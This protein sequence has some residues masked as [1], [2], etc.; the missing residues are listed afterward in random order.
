MKN[1]KKDLARK[2][3][4]EALKRSSQ[5]LKVEDVPSFFAQVVENVRPNQEVRPRRVGGATYQV[6][7]PVPKKRGEFLAMK[8]IIEAARGRS[9]KSMIERL[10]EELINAYQNQGDAVKKKEEVHRIAEANR[11]FAHFR[12]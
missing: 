10:S 1:G 3:V 2:I 12:W 4:Y 11:A 9:G 5:Q 7:I 8:W 6:P